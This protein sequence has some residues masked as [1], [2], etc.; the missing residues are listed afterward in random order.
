MPNRLPVRGNTPNFPAEK[1]TWKILW[2]SSLAAGTLYPTL[3][4][5]PIPTRVRRPQ[6]KPQLLLLIALSAALNLAL[7]TVMYTIKVPLYVDM[8]G[9]LLCALILAATPKRAF[10]CSAVAGVVSFW[11]GGLVNPYLPWFSMTVVTVAAL[12]SFFTGR[13]ATR[14]REQPMNLKLISMIV[15]FGVLTGVV[16]AAVSAPVVAYLFGG[17]TGS[18]TALLV[19]FFLKTGNQLL[20]ATLFSGFTAEPVDKTL[21]LLLAVLLFR[22]TPVSFIDRFRKP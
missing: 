21:Q 13:Y 11:L 19:A 1:L 12:T 18:G 14:L 2:D 3:C 6:V 8:V 4:G 16:A 5:Y 20:K 7:G 15:G 22:A 10:A 9:T 17:V